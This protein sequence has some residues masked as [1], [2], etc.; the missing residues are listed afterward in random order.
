MAK[1]ARPA[2]SKPN[3]FD[4][5]VLREIVKKYDELNEE[6]ASEKGAFMKRA[7]TIGD[8]RKNLLVEAKQ[9]GIPTG[10]LTKT[11][12]VRDHIHKAQGIRDDLEP[13]DQH[14]FDTMAKALGGFAD[15]PLGEAA[16]KSAAERA[17]AAANL[18]EL[19]MQ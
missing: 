14:Q 16:M 9:R 11:L 13:D 4:P 15:T 7:R 19:T 1:R 10:I 12:K 2:N 3:E 17:A 18:D 5:D 8:R 6:L